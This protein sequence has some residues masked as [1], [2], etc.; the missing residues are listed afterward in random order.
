VCFAEIK[1]DRTKVMQ[2]LIVR[3]VGRWLAVSVRHPPAG[4]DVVHVVGEAFAVNN[5]EVR[6]A[7]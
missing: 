3:E 5:V 4:P 1:F 6:M 7:V 2:A